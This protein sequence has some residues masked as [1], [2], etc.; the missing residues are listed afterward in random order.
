[1]ASEESFV[2]LVHYRWS[3]KRKTRSGVKFIDKDPLSIFM[4][5]T[6]RFDDFV[7]SIIQKLG[8]QGVKRVQKLFYRI[9]ISVL[10]DDVNYDCFIIGSDEDLQVLFHC[11]RQF[12]EVR[13]PE[14]LTKLVDVVSS[15]RGSNRNTH[16]IGTV[17][18]FNSRPVGASLSVPVNAPLEEPVASPSFAVDLN[19]SGGGEVGIVDRVPTYLQCGAP[20]GMGD[21]LLDDDDDD[22]VESDLI[23]DDSGDDI[24]ASNPARYVGKCTEFGNGCT[25]LIRLSLRQR[26]GIWEVKRYNGPHTC[27]ATSISSDHRSI[28][29]H[30][31][32]AFIMPMVRADASVCIKDGNSNILPVAFALVKGENA[33]SWSFFLSHLRQHVTPQPGLLVISD[34][35][36]GIKAAFEAPDG[37]WLPPAAYRAFC[38]RH[39][40]ANF[41]LIFKGKDARKLLVECSLCLRAG[42]MCPP[43]C[44]IILLHNGTDLLQKV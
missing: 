33:E 40:A 32:S 14:L 11:R 27:L 18:G 25:W 43:T 13:T 34:K 26:K 44:R 29:Y 38:I 12:S 41:A 17:A 42:G 20:A 4:R 35:H 31:I 5:P 6:T 2:M 23:A 16:T 7:N 19:C 8:L 36:N 24:A 28:D 39:V 37:G 15:S 10:R 9:P 3:I 1:M 30:V 22:D 21:A